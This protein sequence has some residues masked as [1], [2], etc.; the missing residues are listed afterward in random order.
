MNTLK[1]SHEYQDPETASTVC[2]YVPGEP[3][4]YEFFLC[5]FLMRTPNSQLELQQPIKPQHLSQALEQQGRPPVN[6]VWGDPAA[7]RF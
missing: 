1:D 4:F 6:N 2:G 7:R 3:S 5:A